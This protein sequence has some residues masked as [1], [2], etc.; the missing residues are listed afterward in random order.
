MEDPVA[1][2]K[3]VTNKP[4]AGAITAGLFLSEFVPAG[5]KWSHWDVA[6]TAF[7]TSNWKYFK[8]GATGFGLKTLVTLAR[9]L[10]ES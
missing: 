9:E 10:G 2:L 4:E 5:V 1:D 6:G 7:T 3:N 8:P